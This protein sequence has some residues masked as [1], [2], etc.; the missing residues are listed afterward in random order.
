MV[1]SA[2]LHARRAFVQVVIALAALYGVLLDLTRGSPD[3]SVVS[4]PCRGVSHHMLTFG[5][6]RV[7]IARRG[8]RWWVTGDSQVAHKHVH[9]VT[10]IS[11]IS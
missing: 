5:D 7:Q 4:G 11:T 1:V 6:S 2:A 9:M 8:R 10:H 3:L